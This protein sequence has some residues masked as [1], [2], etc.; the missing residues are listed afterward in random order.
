MYLSKLTRYRSR[1]AG[2]LI[3]LSAIFYL[4][5]IFVPSVGHWLP[6]I[7]A[8]GAVALCWP[9]LS[10]SSHQQAG[11]LF[12]IGAALLAWGA[13]SGVHPD[14][15][16]AF[17]RNLPLLTMFVAVSFLSLTNP[18]E[19]DMDQPQGRK[20]FWSTVLSCHLLGAVINLSIIFVVGDRLSRSG[21]L[22]EQQVRVLMRGFCSGAY[23]SPFFVAAGV[24][25][26]YAPGALWQHTVI[27]GLMLVVPMLLVTFWEVNRTGI[28]EF[29][30][31]PL[32]KDSLVMPVILAT[33]VLVCHH[34]FSNVSIL[35]LISLTAPVGA[36]VFMR[37]R[38]RPKALLFYVENKLSN[39]SSQFAL[40]LAAGVFSTGIAVM[41][42]AYPAIFSFH[43]TSFTPTLFMGVS[44]IMILIG[45]VGVHP[46]VS[47][48]LVSP[49]LQPLTDN[50]DQLAFLYLSV[51]GTATAVSP[52]SGVGLAMI[53]RYQATSRSIL[54][55]N[56]VYM[57]LMWLAAGAVN[58]LLYR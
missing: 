13:V 20:G 42:Q 57:V 24:A 45:L 18:T 4:L 5:A 27:S 47:V 9:I 33:V 15:M 12:L 26:T 3:L 52:L 31:Y 6:A 50:F 21:K 30:G 48:S 16:R 8:W 22:T 34:L 23:W 28:Q 11:T 41:I 35:T 39:V 54:K 53:S 37:E 17:T 19:A 25:M 1:L 29:S 38:P 51:W 56:S 2:W 14:V 32:R 36:M 40:F 10:R 55:S 58:W 43:A 7:S 44:A 46:V 49:F